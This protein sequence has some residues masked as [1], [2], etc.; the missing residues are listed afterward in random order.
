MITYLLQTISTGFNSSS[1]VNPNLITPDN[2]LLLIGEAVVGQAP[3]AETVRHRL[4]STSV[5]LPTFSLIYPHSSSGHPNLHLGHPF[6]SLFADVVPTW[7]ISSDVLIIRA[8]LFKFVTP[9]TAQQ[10]QLLHECCLV[11]CCSSESWWSELWAA[12]AWLCSCNGD[13]SWFF[14]SAAA[15]CVCFFFVCECVLP[16]S[17]S[18]P[19]EKLSLLKSIFHPCP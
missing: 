8:R 19:S 2:E 13:G 15:V 11:L 17:C 12:V 9:A 4:I 1:F 14:F 18:P 5:S 7:A 10:I 16:V 3:K 6:S